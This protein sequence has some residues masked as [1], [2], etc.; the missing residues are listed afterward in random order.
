MVEVHSGSL[1]KFSGAMIEHASSILI[2]AGT[3]FTHLDEDGYGLVCMDCVA[4]C[5][6]TNWGSKIRKPLTRSQWKALGDLA[7]KFI[8]TNADVERGEVSINGTLVTLPKGKHMDVS[9]ILSSMGVTLEDISK[10]SLDATRL[11]HES[12]T[13]RKAGDEQRRQALQEELWNLIDC[14]NLFL[15]AIGAR[16][17]EATGIDMGDFGGLE[18]SACAR[19]SF[20]QAIKAVESEDIALG[21]TAG[22]AAAV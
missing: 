15:T 14:R 5:L 4:D 21:E 13:A 3:D 17:V 1:S 2:N 6:K 11:N 18:S 9:N 20:E 22:K 8:W 7:Q 19:W 12:E 10:W 16:V